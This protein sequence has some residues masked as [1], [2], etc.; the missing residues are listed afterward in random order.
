MKAKLIKSKAGQN[1]KTQ[2][3]LCEFLGFG[4]VLLGTLTVRAEAILPPARPA[5]Q[6]EVDA[7]VERRKYVSPATL[8]M[9]TLIG[10]NAGISAAT[11]TNIF[12]Y[13]F[14]AIGG[15][16][17]L[18]PW[19]A[20]I[21]GAQHQL[22]NASKL[23]IGL[24]NTN[25]GAYSTIAGGLTNSITGTNSFIGGGEN[26]TISGYF[27]FI[28]ISYSDNQE[29]P[30][31]DG[32]NITA[33]YS[34]AG[35]LED[36]AI[37]ADR[38]FLG[39]GKDSV[40]DGFAGAIVGGQVNW[41]FGSGGSS[42]TVSTNGVYSFIGGGNANVI[43]NGSY[44]DQ[45]HLTHGG[46]NFGVIGGGYD[47]HI[48]AGASYSAILGSAKNEVSAPFAF[49]IGHYKTNSEAGLI[50]LGYRTL[51]LNVHS[52][53]NVDFTGALT[54]NGSGLTSVPGTFPLND[55]G[56]FN[57]NSA[58]H[59]GFLKFSVGLQIDDSASATHISSTDQSHTFI[60]GPVG[61]GTGLTNLNAAS[62]TPGSTAAPFNG[63]AIT[64]LAKGPVVIA[65]TGVTVTTNT[66]ADTGQK[67]YTVS[68]NTNGGLFLQSPVLN[69][70]TFVTGPVELSGSSI[71]AD[72]FT[73]ENLRVSGDL[74]VT[75]QITGNLS[76]ANT[77]TGNGGGL[78]NLVVSLTPWT[79]DIDGAG[80][81]LTN[82]GSISLGSNSASSGNSF[83]GGV[84]DSSSGSYV[85][86]DGGSFSGG[87]FLGSDSSYANSSYGSFSGGD[88]DSSSGSYTISSYGS[89][90]GGGFNSSTN[91]YANSDN[92]SFSVGSFNGSDNSYTE[93]HYGSFSGG[94]F[95]SSI[96]SYAYSDSG[97][98]SGGSFSGSVGSFAYSRYGSFSGGYFY[99]SDSSSAFSDSGSFSGGN[100]ES[101]VGSSANSYSGSF[102]GG[103]FGWSSNVSLTVN[104][105]L[106]YLYSPNTTNI[107]LT[108]DRSIIIASP[109]NNY[110]ASFESTIGIVG[111]DGVFTGFSTNGFVGNGSG[112]TNA[113]GSS[114]A[115]TNDGRA[116]LFTNAANQIA[117]VFTNAGG[118]ASTFA[119]H[120]A[121]KKLIGSAASSVLATTLTD[122]TGTGIAVFGTAPTFT[123]KITTPQTDYTTNGNPVVPDFALG[124]QL[125]KTNAAFA[126][127]APVNVDT[128]KTLAQTCV[129]IVTNSTAAA[130]L[131]TAPA[132]IH[133][134]GTWYVT[135]VT[136]FTFFQYAQLF[137]NAIALP[138][139]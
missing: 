67:S 74:S 119:V 70:M 57:Q 40:V 103:E 127:L 59:V 90:S 55:V 42:P 62:L 101:S 93:S 99:G 30:G 11:A 1:S 85:V 66:A 100:F 8:S 41:I 4:L 24:N 14:N 56:D 81:N 69:S 49:S 19:T 78:T 86:S 44:Y 84:F 47:N 106:G 38:S 16:T 76:F 36:S 88:F 46:A 2:K 112:L 97:S 91:S 82:G 132:S 26:G 121:N 28:G 27:D 39:I 37:G 18:S 31:F 95:N 15:L 61:D 102:S 23:S 45:G 58:E 71:F 133:T 10:T 94:N 122:E 68:A 43:G 139:W 136:T 124:Y 130:V 52:N 87:Y 108:L 32:G 135:N 107:S 50:A 72:G 79:T 137:T 129:V 9:T 105:G 98:F 117:G 13:Q 111:T 63:V 131:V 123:T 92:G 34:F 104:S 80:F 115:A 134:Q 116:L 125:F 60:L 22:T 96:N 12:N 77:L 118:S 89:F 20:D 53:G 65:S 17:N 48:A 7:G 3:L 64:N 138:L 25:T 113:S 51:G 109:P 83:S 35:V 73:G 128:T 110:T 126:F 33:N 5:S 29:I 6:A 75:G 114:F 21:N 120:D 54:G